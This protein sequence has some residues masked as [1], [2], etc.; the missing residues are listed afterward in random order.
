MHRPQILPSHPALITKYKTG[1]EYGNFHQSKARKRHGEEMRSFICAVIC[2]GTLMTTLFWLVLPIGEELHRPPRMKRQPLK[3]T[4]Y[5][6]GCQKLI[7]NTMDLYSQRWRRLR[8][9]YED[10]RFKMQREG[11]AVED[12]IVSKASFPVGSNITDKVMVTR[13]L[14]SFFPPRSPFFNKT[15]DTCSVVGNG[16]ILFDS[17]C[18]TK[19]DSA[20]FVIRCNL[21]PLHGNFRKHVGTKSSFVTANPSILYKIQKKNYSQEITEKMKPYGDAIIALP[22]QNPLVFE[23]ISVLRELKS[24]SRPV[25]LNPSYLRKLTEFW[26][27][28]GVKAARLSSGLLM[29]S[30]ALGVCRNVHVYGFWPFSVH[31]FGLYFLPHHY[32][33]DTLPRKFHKMPVEFE[34]LLQLHTRGVIRLQLGACGK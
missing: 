3:P 28:R 7:Q 34:Q 31:P 25:F 14:F 6:K 32:Y 9:H 18:G 27:S 23:T 19:I 20:D 13:P 5:C 30:M 8:G 22:D 12:A 33:D 26:R 11:I 17:H 21:P 1:C 29:V 10:F 16:G 4:Q 24:K 15:W 2:F